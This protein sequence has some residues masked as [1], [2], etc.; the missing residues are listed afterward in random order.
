MRKKNSCEKCFCTQRSL[1]MSQA[2]VTIARKESEIEELKNHQ[3]IA[4]R[5]LHQMCI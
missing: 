3:E 1:K 4:C 2:P 5:A